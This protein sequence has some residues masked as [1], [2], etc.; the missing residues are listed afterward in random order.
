MTSLQRTVAPA[1]GREACVRH[2]TACRALCKVSGS[3]RAASS[4]APGAYL[5]YRTI[6][7]ATCTSVPCSK[8][9]S[10]SAWP[11][12]VQWTVGRGT[13]FA[14]PLA[15]AATISFESTVILPSV[16]P[17]PSQPGR[18]RLLSAAPPS[19]TPRPRLLLLVGFCSCCSRFWRPLGV[20]RRLPHFCPRP[21]ARSSRDRVQR[22]LPLAWSCTRSCSYTYTCC[23]LVRLFPTYFLSRSQ[24]SRVLVLA[25]VRDWVQF[26]AS[27]M[28]FPHPSAALARARAPAHAP[29]PVAPAAP[30]AVSPC[31][32]RRSLVRV[33]MRLC[34]PNFRAKIRI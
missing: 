24:A 7:A 6:G 16:R 14:A 33:R 18:G 26:F 19:T 12:A 32:C 30:T 4:L 2:G 25:L 21:C 8:R 13:R 27:Y 31:P 5:L 22:L 29:A 28:Q 10:T 11:S 34:H 23:S 15:A 20:G 3:A 1:A 17:F 9:R